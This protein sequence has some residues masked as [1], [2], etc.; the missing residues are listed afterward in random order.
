L[1]ATQSQAETPAP[2]EPSAPLALPAPEAMLALIPPRSSSA[3]LLVRQGSD[4]ELGQRAK[5]QG[6]DVLLEPQWAGNTS[7]FSDVAYAIYRFNLGGYSGPQTLKLTWIEPP[8]CAMLWLGLSRW[9]MAR[10][11]WRPGP[12]SGFIN[13]GLDGLL[14]FTKTDTGDVL[15]ALVL[16]GMAPASLGQAQLGA[17]AQGDWCMGGHDAQRTGQSNIIGP[18][19]N[20]LRWALDLGSD[21]RANPVIAADGSIYVGTFH[22]DEPS[23]FFAVNPNGTVKWS[24]ETADRIGGAAAVAPDGTVYAASGT[25]SGDGGEGKLYAVNTDGTPKWTLDTG[26]L[27]APLIDPSG[28]VYA[29]SFNGLL[30]AVNPD[31]TLRWAFVGGDELRTPALSAN[32]TV[33]VWCA[34]HN[35]YAVNSDGSQ[36]WASAYASAII[37]PVVSPNGT[38]YA[39]SIDHSLYAIDPDGTQ[40]WAYTAEWFAWYASLGF[41]G[42]LY[43]ACDQGGLHAVASDGTQ[44]WI[45]VTYWLMRNQPAIGADGTVYV[46]SNDTSPGKPNSALLAINPDGTLKWSYPTHEEMTAPAIGNDGTLYV[47]SNDGHLYA[48]GT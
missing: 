25:V 21:I 36:E 30:Y 28:V 14:P 1:P 18:Q 8:D 26:A 43:V 48:F 22:T 2:Q 34:D 39:A 45:Y 47:G 24:F 3:A 38:V 7:P 29:A 40:E 37:M 11:D 33:Y 15:V 9:N 31:G 10:W 20:N 41:D 16:L 4:F 6:D 42:S 19:T 5:A 35:L 44:K 32:G 12:P 17:S 23:E 27:R 13:F 46:M